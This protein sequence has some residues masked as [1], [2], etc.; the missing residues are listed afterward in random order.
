MKTKKSAIKNRKNTTKPVKTE[1]NTPFRKRLKNEIKDLLPHVT[2]EVCMKTAIA[3][4]LEYTTIKAYLAGKI[5]DD[6]TGIQLI[7]VLG[8][9]IQQGYDSF[10]DE[11]DAQDAGFRFCQVA[12]SILTTFKTTN[13][14]NILLEHLEKKTNDMDR[15][16]DLILA[17]KRN[18]ARF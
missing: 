4:K 6:A 3:L 11:V 9:I 14:M 2:D 17:S 18:N 10:A 16:L 15:K 13:S 5:E 1:I 12:E 8:A 7:R